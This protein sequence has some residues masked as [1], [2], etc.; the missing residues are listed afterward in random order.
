VAVLPSHSHDE[1]IL[2]IEAPKNVSINPFTSTEIW[3]LFVDSRHLMEESNDKFFF[4]RWHL[5]HLP[6]IAR[7]GER[8]FGWCGT[9]QRS[10]AIGYV[11]STKIDA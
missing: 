8:S 5:Q 2:L 9:T 10:L 6:Q 4:C 7:K 1:T 11:G 3:P